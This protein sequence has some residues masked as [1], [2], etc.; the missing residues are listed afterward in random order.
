MFSNLY[1]CE[2]HLIQMEVNRFRAFAYTK[3]T[4]VESLGEIITSLD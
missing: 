4:K 3:T 1:K 2:F